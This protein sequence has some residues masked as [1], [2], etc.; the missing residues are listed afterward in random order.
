MRKL[1]FL[2]FL[3]GTAQLSAQNLVPLNL[4]QI[5]GK[6]NFDEVKPGDTVFIESGDR[7]ELLINNF[8]GTA[9]Q[10]IIFFPSQGTVPVRIRS[11]LSYGIS[12]RSCSFIRLSGWQGEDEY[13]GIQILELDHESS[14]GISLSEKSTDVEIDHIEVGDSGFAGI[15]AKTDP[16]CGDPETQR[17]GFV[18]K[19][20]WI[21]HCYI[22]D[23]GAEGIYAGHTSFSGYNL[24]DCG[25]VSPTVLE[26]V[27][28]YQNIIERTGWDGI[29]VTSA[30]SDCQIYDNE[31]IDCAVSQVVG[32]MGGILIGGGTLADCYNNL[33]VDCYGTGILVF[34]NGGT[35]IFNNVILRSAKRYAPENPD[36]REHGIYLNDKTQLVKS[37]YGVFSN[38][39]IQPKS[40]CIRIAETVDFEVLIYNNIMV[41]PGAWS[42]YEN[43][44]T[45]KIGNDSYVFVQGE[46]SNVRKAANAT[47]RSP[48]SPRFIDADSDN[49]HLKINSPYIDAGRDLS[50]QARVNFDFEY[51]ERPY[52]NGYDIGAYE[53]GNPSGIREVENGENH[54]QTAFLSFGYGQ[55]AVVLHVEKPETLSWRLMGLD[56][57]IIKQDNMIFIDMGEYVI[58]M[59]NANPG[60]YVLQIS[61]VDWRQSEK[62]LVY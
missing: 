54:I 60:I 2:L 48:L 45:D 59:P 11:S 29:Q 46:N 10:P 16:V 23:T 52:G 42:V 21:H 51:T 8:H 55:G 61:A 13:Y 22:H 31:V 7:A 26:G 41:D 47:V 56:G 5:N 39:I 27:R 30:I 49:Y 14:V 25:M 19:N 35:R 15:L 43:D 40:D 32:H 4:E 6:G 12:L 1:F 37:Y 20:T 34:G 9:E 17:G 50:D 38:T 3:L 44:N 58:D 33:I 62:L 28:I 18:Q 24:P 57:R 53:Y 36:L